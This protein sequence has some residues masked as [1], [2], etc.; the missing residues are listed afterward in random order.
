LQIYITSVS[1][2]L[3]FTYKTCQIVAGASMIRQF[4]EFSKLNFWR[5]FAI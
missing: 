1:G 2:W 4:H 3:H 5:V